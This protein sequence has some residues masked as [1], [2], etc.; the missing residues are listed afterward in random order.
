MS[1]I[2]GN[3]ARLFFLLGG[4]TGG[5]FKA[6]PAVCFPASRSRRARLLP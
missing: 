4:A 5:P 6:D 3:S 2:E 1:R